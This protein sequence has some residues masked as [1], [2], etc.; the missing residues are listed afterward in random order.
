MSRIWSD[1]NRYQKWMEIEIAACEAWAELGRV[2]KESAA[3]IRARAGFNV[4]RIEEIEAETRHDVIAFVSC[5]AEYV[6][7]DDSRFIHMGLTSS[8]V[9]DTAL[10]LQLVESA[11]LIIEDIHKLMAVLKRR[12]YETRHIPAMGRSHGIHAEPISFGLKFALWYAE[13]ERNLKRMQDARENI[14]YGQ[15]SGAVG[16]FANVDP[17]VEAFVCAKLGLK[18]EPISTQVIQRDRHAQYF[19]TL[20]LVGASMEQIAV[21]IRHLQRTEV[22]EAMEPFGKGQKGS[23]AMPHKKNPIISENL[24]GIARLLRGYA[25]SA[26]ENVALWHERDI[27]HSS[28]ERVIGPDANILTDYALNRLTNLLDGLVIF[29]ENIERNLNLTGGLWHSQSVLLALVNAGMA[30]DDAYRW[31]Q[32][33]ALKIWEEKGDFKALLKSDADIAK[34]LNAEQIEELFDLEHHLAHVD[35]IFKRVFDE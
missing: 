4:A 34:Y 14:A 20:A 22:L 17:R 3:N 33:N 25:V 29:P 6:N 12:A 8:D 26:F 16:T 23:S 32:R 1:E 15:I 35:T 5:M 24:T 7:S 10:A 30:R 31:V 2:P 21:E 28:V 13:M 18:P 11:D 27:S 19:A 9:L